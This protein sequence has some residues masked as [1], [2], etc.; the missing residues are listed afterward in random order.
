M[1]I[2]I[3]VVTVC[4][5]EH[6]DMIIIVVVTVCKGEHGDMIIIVVVTGKG[7]HGVIIKWW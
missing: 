1:V 3:V 7:E 2:I 4:K 6:G 5:G